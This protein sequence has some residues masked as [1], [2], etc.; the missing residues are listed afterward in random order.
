MEC[1]RS[2]WDPSPNGNDHQTG[3]RNWRVNV[4]LHDPVT[5]IVGDGKSETTFSHSKIRSCER[6]EE[7]GIL[8]YANRV[9][10]VLC[11]A[12]ARFPTFYLLSDRLILMFRRNFTEAYQHPY[13]RHEAY[14]T[15]YLKMILLYC[16]LLSIKMRKERSPTKPSPSCF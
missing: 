10:G 15:F 5:E 1:N 13:W 7:R 8:S 2:L 14:S 11:S 9:G 12:C 3:R 6:R 4:I 16:A